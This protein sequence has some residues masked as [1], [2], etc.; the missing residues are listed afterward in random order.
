MTPHTTIAREF[1]N[2]QDDGYEIFRTAPIRMR[3]TVREPVATPLFMGGVAL[4][5][6]TLF[7]IGMMVLG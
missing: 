3:V 2:D 1:T 5:F 7:S 6:L 4:W